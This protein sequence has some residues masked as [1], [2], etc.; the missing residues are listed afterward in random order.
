MSRVGEGRAPVRWGASLADVLVGRGGASE[1]MRLALAWGITLVGLFLL[2]FPFPPSEGGVLGLEETD[3]AVHVVLFGAM[4]WGWRRVW[5]NGAKARLGVCLGIVALALAVEFIQPVTGRSQDLRDWGAGVLGAAVACAIPLGTVLRL[6]GLGMALAVCGGAY[7]APS[8]CAL[9]EEWRAWPSLCDAKCS[10]S[11]R[12]WMLNGIEFG[13]AG[14][15][16]LVSAAARSEWPGLFRIPAKHDW[17]EAGDLRV[18]WTWGGAS[19]A[20]VALRIDAD[21]EGEGEPAYGDRFQMELESW[22]GTNEVTIPR[23][24]WTRTGGGGHLD[25][26]KIRQWG[27]FLVNA[28]EFD[29]FSVDEARFLSPMNLHAEP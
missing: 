18:R 20:I 11:A 29:Y 23:K 7:V 15:V 10:W 3:K 21:W 14:T 12:R 9:V 27:F 1:R 24:E 8:A 6:V 16:Q 2:F 5:G 4:A 25:D 19:K 17:S 22:P 13:P 26:T 28:P